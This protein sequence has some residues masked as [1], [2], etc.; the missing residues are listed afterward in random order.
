MKVHATDKPKEHGSDLAERGEGAMVMSGNGGR[1][2]SSC[3]DTDGS[4]TLEESGEVPVRLIGKIV[5][6]RG[7]DPYVVTSPSVVRTPKE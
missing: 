2:S 1:A 7:Y 4:L 6:I 5:Y 3:V